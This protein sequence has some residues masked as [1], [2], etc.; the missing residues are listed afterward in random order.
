MPQKIVSSEQNENLVE[1]LLE[2]DADSNPGSDLTSPIDVA[3]YGTFIDDPLPEQLE[4]YFTLTEA[5]L[6][7][8]SQRRLPHTKLGMALQICTLRFLG[9]F[10]S[11]PTAVPVNAIDFVTKQLGF[12][13]VDLEPY[14][15]TVRLHFKH[16]STIRHHLGYREFRG[17]SV[18]SVARLLIQR[19]SVSEENEYVLF[20]LVT[21]NLVDTNIVLPG[22]TTIQRLI[23]RAR[24]RVRQ[25]LYKLIT[26]R[27]SKT[28]QRKLEPLLLVPEG[29]HRT[30]L[31]QLR[32]PPT[33][34]SS[35]TILDAII[36]V[37]RIRDYTLST[38]KV[39][40][41]A[42]NR[43]AVIVRTGMTLKASILAQQSQERCMATLA[44]TMRHLEYQAI[45][46]VLIVFDT[47]MRELGLRAQRRI[48]RERL[49]SLKDL[50][51][52]ALTLRD[53]VRLVLDTNVPS[54]SL[55]SLILK[56]FGESALQ[57][58]VLSVTELTTTI[59]DS[60]TEVWQNTFKVISKFITPLLE[61]ITFDGTPAAKPLLEGIIF[62]KRISKAG[63]AEWGVPPRGFI[64][65]AWIPIIFHVG[66][67]GE[68]GNF[69]RSK[70]M[71]CLT[72]QLY[73]TLKRG[74]VFVI[75]SIKHIDP[76]AR[77]LDD[78][79]WKRVKIEVHQSLHLPINGNEY[80][81]KQAKL[82]DA[83]LTRFAQSMND[84]LS[85]KL[86]NEGDEIKISVTPLEKLPDSE[87]LLELNQAITKRLPEVGL[88]EVILELNART[89]FIQAMLEPDTNEKHRQP[90]LT[91]ARRYAHNLE[92][93]VAAVLL[94]EACN[95][96]LKS[97]A[98]EL[99]PALRI[100]RLTMVKDR[101]FSA[102][103]IRRGNTRLVN[104]H[105]TRGLS[106]KWGGG[107][108]ASAD[109]LRF[110]VPTKNIMTGT[111]SKYFGSK[112]GVT[113]YTLVSDQYT[114]L[115][116]TV[117]PGTMRDSLY[118]LSGLLEQETQLDPREIMTDTAGYSDLIFGLF[119]L[120]GY[121]FSPRLKDV[122]KAR[123]WRIDRSAHYNG[124]D[125]LVR[126]PINITLIHDQW[127]DVMR[128]IGS[129]K[130][131]KV[132][133][134]DVMRVLAR[135]GTLSGLG[136]A[137]EEIGRIAKTMYLC[138]YLQDE[139][140]RRR[141]HTQLSHG[142]SR[143]EVARH[144]FYGQK[145]RIYKRYQRGLEEQ[146]GA[147]GLVVNVVVVW[148]T[149][150][151]SAILDLLKEMGHDVLDQD[152]ARVSPLKTRHIKVHGEY[153][154]S[155]HPD[156]VDGDLRPLRDPNSM[157]GLRDDDGNLEVDEYVNDNIFDKNNVIDE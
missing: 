36:R 12:D 140:Y 7:L 101:Y 85:V 33:H 70:Y 134:T 121:R 20:D 81:E 128:L 31:D 8:L 2:T 87:F 108:V 88:A 147:L 1:V 3:T 103:A 35:K 104:Y 75:G 24:K 27:L 77:L 102:D 130:L 96:G 79:A 39:D 84:N 10:L 57:N 45:D 154:F 48:Q 116:G 136:R 21:Q 132:K 66:S 148:N 91:P 59:E 28:Y 82:L 34:S 89:R 30:L 80:V 119:Q 139:S 5:D 22:A 152:V 157:I 58:A 16:Q 137:I 61:T 141:I 17:A 78:D 120:L 151:M 117:V 105:V 11:D 94:A 98:Q 131:G 126:N 65:R 18:L 67:N 29:D 4:T 25:R 112:R 72:Q 9:T 49:R 76:R 142:E 13:H 47:L 69:N 73:K 26:S 144:I 109:G 50:D 113:F 110:V 123:F 55:R 156:V 68:D 95:I 133:A 115:H 127:D 52:A 14:K 145:G 23:R 44:V 149:D 6:E 71:V 114:Q 38:F 56:E 43:L 125:D 124:I 40:D 46:E 42:E 93:S 107:E 83:R 100:D 74:D 97:V 146:L 155:L 19:L 150:Y 54:R 138:D 92:V 37:Q 51:A 15:E 62:A 90:Q 135:G 63:R 143:G 53:A 99:N 106:Q 86:K 64:P 118:L 129:L 153:N 122:G 60:E 111:N 32:T 41:I